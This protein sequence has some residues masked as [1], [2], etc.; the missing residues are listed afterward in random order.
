MHVN[1]ALLEAFPDFARRV[2]TARKVSRDKKENPERCGRKK[3]SQPEDAAQSCCGKLGF[4]FVNV[5]IF[6]RQFDL[7]RD[8]F[9]KWKIT[10]A[11]EFWRRRTRDACDGR[12]RAV[13]LNRNFLSFRFGQRRAAD[14]AFAFTAQQ[15]AGVAGVRRL[16][17]LK[18]FRKALRQL[19]HSVLR[20]AAQC[21]DGNFLLRGINRHGFQR[22]FLGKRVHDGTREAGFS[23]A[24]GHT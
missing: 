3:P 24:A 16:D 9:R 11:P 12:A 10:P 13:V 6:V 5:M 21:G 17:G 22:R 8:D 18:F 1:R 4:P 19:F 2:K 15:S 14:G 7:A 20:D 23:L